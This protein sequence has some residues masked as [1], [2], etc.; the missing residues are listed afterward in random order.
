[1]SADGSL[2]CQVAL[3]KSTLEIGSHVIEDRVAIIVMKA[4]LNAAYDCQV[5][6]LTKV[7]IL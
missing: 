1:M 3:N 2:N 6:L 7:L 4:V 5:I